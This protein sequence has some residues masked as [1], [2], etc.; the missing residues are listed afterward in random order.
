MCISEI[1]AEDAGSDSPFGSR[2]ALSLGFVV[3]ASL[4]LPLDAVA[5]DGNIGVQVS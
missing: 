4:A 1:D 5:L 3:V 2:G